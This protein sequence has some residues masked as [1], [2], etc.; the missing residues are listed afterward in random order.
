MHTMRKILIAL[1]ACVSCSQ[2]DTSDEAE[3][4]VRRLYEAHR[5]WDGVEIDFH[6]SNALSPYFDASLTQLLL[7]DH[8]CELRVGEICN[9][10][11]D[12]VLAAQDYDDA[13]LRELRLERQA[14]PGG[15]VVSVTFQNLDQTQHIAYD[16]VCPPAGCRITD[17]RYDTGPSLRTL[18]ST[19]VEATSR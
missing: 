17:V 10:D 3:A 7:D 19:P 6:A 12:P 15:I 4:R 9:L 13:G 11:F 16:V 2:A 1:L 5:P 8:A 18:L 14:G